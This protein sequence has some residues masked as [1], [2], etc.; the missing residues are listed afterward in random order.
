[1]LDTPVISLDLMATALTLGDADLK[2]A[3]LDGVD[4]LPYLTGKAKGAPHERLFWRAGENYAVREGAWK[5]WVVQSPK[6]GSE[7]FLFN[8]SKDMGEKQ[9]LA[10]QQ[11]Q[12]VAR[13]KAAYATWN[14][15]NIAPRFAPR[16][17]DVKV[18]GVPVRLAF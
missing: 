5:L 17:I 12:I 8:L 2:S 10:A 7:T 14:A 15:G 11:P 3:P 16:T 4:L 6:G 1:M 18:N 13:L 9:N